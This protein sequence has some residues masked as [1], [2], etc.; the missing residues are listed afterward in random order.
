VVFPF[1][2]LLQLT[3]LGL[4]QVTIKLASPHGK[5]L[6]QIFVYNL[7]DLLVRTTSRYCS[8]LVTFLKDL[9]SRGPG[10]TPAPVPQYCCQDT[11]WEARSDTMDDAAQENSRT[12]IMLV[13]G[14]AGSFLVIL[15][16]E[17]LES[18]FTTLIL[19]SRFVSLRGQQERSVSTRLSHC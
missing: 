13:F 7:T 14:P 6:F 11:S 5:S 3:Y 9:I 15:A 12:F 10:P 16:S 2:V 18:K 4:S 17:P 8:V 1:W 19:G